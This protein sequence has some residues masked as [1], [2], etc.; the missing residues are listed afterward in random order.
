M[1]FP[2]SRSLRLRLLG[3]SELSRGD[4]P[5]RVAPVGERLLAYLAIRSGPAYRHAVA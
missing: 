2:E 3:R 1:S 5:L 4:S